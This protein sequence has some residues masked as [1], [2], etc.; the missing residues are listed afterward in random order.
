M[1]G[2]PRHPGDNTSRRKFIRA[3]ALTGLS[4][5]VAPALLSRH[6]NMV[7]AE[8]REDALHRRVKAELKVFTDWLR[9]NRVRGYVGE[10]GW[11][12]TSDYPKWNALAETWYRDADAANLWVTAWA[13]GEWWI[14]PYYRLA[15]YENRTGADDSGVESANV[16]APILE[17]HPSTTSYLRGINVC[18]GEFGAPEPM[19]SVSRFSNRNPG[20]YDTHYH[21]DSQ[22]TFDYLARRNIKLVKLAFRWERLQRSLGG[23]LDP[24][25]HARLRDAVSR[26]RTAGLRVLLD[27]HNYGEYYL[28]D[29]TRGVRRPIGSTYVTRAHFA[30]VWRKISTAFRNNPGVV[31]YSLQAEPTGMPYGTRG[32]ERASQAALN[33]IRRCGDT[34]LVTVSGY[35]WAGVQSWPRN[36]PAK[37]INDPVDN[38]RYEGHHY[39]DRNYSGSYVHSYADELADARARGY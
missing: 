30:D 23:P 5:L 28:F 14:D 21:Y 13:T 8:P 1:Y 32:W 29:G 36:H 20:I 25:E 24:T 11:P 10:I 19:A 26:A 9:D 7:A 35:D 12:D 27:M 15:I 37:W 2:T 38:H 34:K 6:G 3:A 18:G 22:A 4:A 16:Q 39:W 31:G 17:S 33:A